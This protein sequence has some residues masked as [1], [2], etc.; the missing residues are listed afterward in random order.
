M[1]KQLLNVYRKFR[2]HSPSMLVGR[3]A[4]LALRN[5]KILLKFQELESEGKVQIYSEEENENYFDVFGEPDTEQQ[6]K[7]IVDSLETYGCY[8]VASK[9]RE[10]CDCC[11]NDEWDT[12]DSIGMCVGYKDA[13]SPFENPYVID[14]MAA[15]VEHFEKN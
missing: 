8:W 15:A 10:K 4:E 14:L 1:T 3:N 6:R 7:R 2:E 9:V 11:G 12:V 13:E 5:A